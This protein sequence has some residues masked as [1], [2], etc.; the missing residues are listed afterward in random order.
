M[1]RRWVAACAVL[2]VMPIALPLS[3][4]TGTSASVELVAHTMT[5]TSPQT[6]GPAGG[7]LS[8][9][10]DRIDQRTAT[11]SQVSYNFS[12]DGT[13]VKA[14]VLDS[15]VNASHPEFGFRVLDGWSY[16]A[17][18]T[19]LNT[20][21]AALSAY[22]SN[23]NANNAIEPC[24]ND[25]SH[26]MDPSTFD[27]PTNVD[28]S[29]TGKSDNDGHGTHVAGIIAGDTTGVAKNVSIVPVRA[30]DSC[31]NGTTTMILE[32][33]AWILS[34]HQAG[35]RAVLNLSIGFSG[36]VASVDSAITSIMNEGVVVVAA[37]GNSATTACGTTPASTIGTISVGAMN[38]TDTETYFSNYGLCV[39]IFS[40]GSAIRSTFPYAS[41][42]ANTYFTLSGTS[43]A[44][45]FV[46]GAISRFLQQLQTGPTSF[47]T[48]PTAAWTWISNNA[49]LNA[50]TPFSSSRTSQTPNRLLYVPAIPVHIQQLSARAL[51][52]AAEVSWQNAQQGATY[53]AT[54]SPG[55]G[56]CTA[57]SV[58][59]CTISGLSNGTTYTIS[60]VGSN[61]DG[62][63]VA[64]TTTVT[65][66]APPVVTIAPPVSIAPVAPVAP[67]E[68]SAMV[69]S[70]SVMISWSAVTSTAPVTY[71]VT[72]S[73]GATVCTTT[74]TSCVV[75]GLVNGALYSYS[76]SSQAAGVLS[77]SSSTPI[78]VRPGFALMKTTVAKKSKTPLSWFVK[79]VSN[80]KK[81]WSESGPCSIVSSRLVAPTKATACKVTLK[82]AKTSKYPAMSTQVTITVK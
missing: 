64:S 35:E 42:V 70:K 12:E 65:P 5:T 56:T 60:V 75:S 15:G 37:A 63:G 16:R 77:A 27:A 43:M 68:I 50:I 76:V 33:L 2:L 53:V 48:G 18:Q 54:A 82:V 62:V 9:G 61:A 23:P 49:T 67:T 45:P 19:A 13:G 81:T 46:S 24:V 78:A 40:P 74:S 1:I 80:G 17:S 29:D 57:A 79:T 58:G 72:S 59:S 7:A 73:T 41:G 8:W 14:Y 10:L 32:G 3:T 20:Y 34:N 51:D 39:D 31:G 28:A 11:S 47:S 55:N 25:G 30:L 6:T 26:A 21:T 36:Q 66:V 69:S 52:G 44:A 22:A 38:S 4:H 71:V